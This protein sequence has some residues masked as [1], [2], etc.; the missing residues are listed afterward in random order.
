MN[1]H[2]VPDWLLERFAAGEMNERD[3]QSLKQRLEQTGEWY[4]LDALVESNRQILTTFPAEQVVPEIARRLQRATPTR[5]MHPTRWG[6]GFLAMCTASLGI[7][8]FVRA[9]IT[10]STTH[11][12]SLPPETVALKGEA[13][14]QLRVYRKKITGPELLGTQ[15]SLHTGDVLQL[16]YL[17][18]G[19]R[20][21][22][23]ASI[24]SRGTMTLHLPEHAGTAVPLEHEGEKALPHSYELDD[25]PGF[26]RFL[27]ITSNTPFPSSLAMDLLTNKITPPA[28]VL[29]YEVSFSKESP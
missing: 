24:D 21:G 17:S 14:P 23:I 29:T 19:H 18:A 27:F 5:Q 15:A 16:R 8:L 1:S 4:R 13:R 7:F 6:L 25:S 12:I 20:Y 2:R 10:P 26:E 9:G 22:V 11:P 28:S 3:A